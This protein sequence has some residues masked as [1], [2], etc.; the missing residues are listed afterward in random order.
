[1][2]RAGSGGRLAKEPLLTAMPVKFAG[3]IMLQH[4]ITF[5]IVGLAFT[6]TD[7]LAESIRGKARLKQ[8]ALEQVTQP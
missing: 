6:G 2:I 1:M 8:P 7:C 3:K 4:S 5:G